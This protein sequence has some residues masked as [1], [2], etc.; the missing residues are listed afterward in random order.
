[1]HIEPV[2]NAV[3]FQ[4]VDEALHSK[5]LNTAKSGV[6]ISAHNAAQSEKPRWGKV[7]HIGPE[8]KDVQPGDFILVDPGKWTMGFYVDDVR[9]WKTDE[10]VIAATADEPG[11]IY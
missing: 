6:L 3:I 11:T 5:F 4:F 8:V 10:T 7:T 9:Y 2:N 1:M